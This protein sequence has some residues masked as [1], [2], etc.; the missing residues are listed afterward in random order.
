VKRILAPGLLVPLLLA[1]AGVGLIIA[2]Q[3]DLD[4]PAA[5]RTLE[6]IP[7]PTQTPTPVPTASRSTGPGVSVSPSPTPQPTLRSTAKAVQIQI[8]TFPDDINVPLTKSKSKATDSFPPENGAF[9]LS[10]SSEP[11]RGTNSYIFAHAREGLFHNLWNVQLGASVKIR[12][13]DG[14]V[15]AYRVT[16]IHPNVAC[17]DDEAPNPGLNPGP[18]DLPLVLELAKNCDEGGF[19]TSQDVDHERLTLQTSQG[20][21]RNWGEFVVIA[22]PV[23]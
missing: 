6:P 15:L 10:G 4:R 14:A 19:W 8:E 1:I 17:P 13:S 20:Y 16:E 23:G 12:M 18:G 2:S 11:G 21:N 5:V 9:I 7:D 22:E 3:L